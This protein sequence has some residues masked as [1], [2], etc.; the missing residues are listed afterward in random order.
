[1]EG[2]SIT[3]AQNPRFKL[4]KSYLQSPEDPDCPWIAVEGPKQ[5]LDLSSKH[6]FALLLYSD[7][8]CIA[9]ILSRQ[10]PPCVCLPSDLLSRLSRVRSHQGVIAFLEK[11]VWNWND[12]SEWILYL[13]GIQDPGNLGTLLR[14]ARATGLFSLVSDLGAVSFF[15]SKVVRASSGS[16]FQVPFV[17]GVTLPELK[18]R[19]YR[20]IAAS[21]YGRES[22]LDQPFAPRT[23]F[24]LG[25]E[26][27]GVT[28]EA[29]EMSDHAFRI[30][31]ETGSDSLNV[32]VAGSLIM[33]HVYVSRQR[34][35][36]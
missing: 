20:V 32:S 25:N 3:S 18:R 15:N 36:K 5:A 29:L 33:Y 12:V 27:R 14:T 8:N 28:P 9:P 31:M 23:A 22:L 13:A 11:P 30:P 7:E 6:R 35:R 10:T 4:W 16:L 19:N 21:A 34:P 26:G 2:E 1:M 17:E 24:L